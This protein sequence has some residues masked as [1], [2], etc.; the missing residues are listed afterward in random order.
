MLEEAQGKLFYIAISRYSPNCI[1]SLARR[2][3]RLAVDQGR[4]RDSAGLSKLAGF[5]CTRVTPYTLDDWSVL[6]NPQDVNTPLHR[7]R[8]QYFIPQVLG[9][10]RISTI[11]LSLLVVKLTESP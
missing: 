11:S 10:E 1:R 9:S 5:E 2:R 8:K 4:A 7:M 6:V 3:D